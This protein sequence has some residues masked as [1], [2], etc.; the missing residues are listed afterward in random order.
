MNGI[1][2]HIITSRSPVLCKLRHFLF[3][4][5]KLIWDFF[6]NHWVVYLAVCT[7]SFSNVDHPL[8]GNTA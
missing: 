6:N 5:F 8:S 2:F 1:I 7:I 3:V 4:T